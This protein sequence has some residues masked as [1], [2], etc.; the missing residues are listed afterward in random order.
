MSD[1]KSPQSDSEGTTGASTAQQ[2]ARAMREETERKQRTRNMAIAGAVVLAG[3]ALVVGGF[4][5]V[6]SFQAD[7]QKVVYPQNVTE[8]GSF[9]VGNETAPVT[10]DVYVDYMCGACSQFEQIFDPV[11]EPLIEDGT[12]KVEYHPLGNMD[13]ASRGTKYSSRSAN[14]TYCIAD[15]EPDKTKPYF[16]AL[17]EQQPRTQTTGLSN[18]QLL[19][20]ATDV[21]VTADIDSCVKDQTYFGYV[22]E[23]R[24]QNNIYA[25]PTLKLNGRQVGETKYDENNQRVP[26]D[27]GVALT[28]DAVTA[29]IKR[30][31]GDA[32]VESTEPGAEEQTPDGA[33]SSEDDGGTATDGAGTDGADGTDVATDEATEGADATETVTP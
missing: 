17:F 33:A 21:G 12:L 2:K 18:D 5:L 29:E 30:L 7:Q 27:Y 4:A 22:A 25:T 9:T 1:S 10:A 28:P 6:R 24:E 14:A 15:V 19:Q 26:N 3:L 8:S 11:F 31:A 23:Q 20:I 32:G 13:G 16:A